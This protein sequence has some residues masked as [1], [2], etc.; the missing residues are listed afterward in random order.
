MNQKNKVYYGEYTLKHWI[1]MILKGNIVLPEYQR[2][3]VWDINKIKI[4][5]N[6]FKNQEFVPPVTIGSF[7]EEDKNKNLILDGQQRLTSLLLVY[8]GIFPNKVAYKRISNEYKQFYD[9][10]DDIIEKP[11]NVLKWNFNVLLEKGD[12]KDKILKSLENYGFKELYKNLDVDVSDDFFTDNYLGFSYLVPM[13][14]NEQKN[15]Y[16]NVFRNIN[17]QGITLLPEE[18]REALYY[19]DRN[20]EKLFIPDFLKMFSK[21]EYK[22]DFVRYL[23]L[24]SQ[25]K[26][27]Q[28]YDELAKG[29]YRKMEKYYEDYIHFIISKD[30]NV[31]GDNGI[32]KSNQLV[33]FNQFIDLDK[34]WKERINKL[35]DYIPKLIKLDIK[36]PSIIDLDIVFFGLIYYVFFEDKIICF[37]REDEIKND[38]KENIEECKNNINHIRNASAFV[39]LR[40]RVQKSI[41]IYERFVKNET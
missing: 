24:L 21:L 41:N 27:I 11:D 17:I 40:N 14:P 32:D 22:I 5:I 29:Y 6:S 7:T 3:F 12:T 33:N 25:Y 39:H 30:H 18:S 35:S 10:N 8:L 36:M 26:K 2:Y 19:L 15:Y 4:L 34:N 16:A 37:D 28:K 1:N 20:Y 23:A 38:I 13:K 9:E 31:K